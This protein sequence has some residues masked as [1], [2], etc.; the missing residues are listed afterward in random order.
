VSSLYPTVGRAAASAGITALPAA[1]TAVAVASR[2][3]LQPAP[4]TAR[5]TVNM[6]S[7]AHTVKGQGVGSCY[8]EQV[9]AVKRGLA[10]VD[11]TE[12]RLGNFDIVHYH[13]I[14][15]R[16]LIERFLTR[17]R[18]VGIAYV[19]F[20][21][22]TLDESLRLPRVARAAFYRYVLFFYNSMDYLVTVNPSFIEK[23]R[24]CGLQRPHLAYIPNFVSEEPF[25][26]VDPAA[27]AAARH[28]L[29]ISDSDF[30]VLGVGQ[31]QTRKGVL[32]FVETARRLPHIRF[33]WAGGFSFGRLSDGYD[34]IQA[35]LADPPDNVHFIGLVDRADMPVL[36]H[37]AD[38]MF[39][40]SYG[41]L[42]PMA[43]LEAQ[44]CRKPVLLRDIPVYESILDGCY[45][46]GDSPETFARRIAQ[47]A[48]DADAYRY[49]SDQ[50]WAAHEVYSEANVLARW[51]QL[52][53]TA[54]TQRR[55]RR[56]KEA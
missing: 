5:L 41:E 34:E 49:W 54:Y 2:T 39:L 30:V 7:R 18:T 29:G 35:A 14:N 47:L 24:L 15:P 11:I 19:H 45:L 36:Y 42:F 40:P 51:D 46:S 37:A 6:R 3:A 9:R 8:E 4:D 13:T 26:A 56:A 55:R 25:T 28:R 38:V 48:T 12:N 43:I 50:S 1:P 52:Y 44:C 16:F 31:L 23:M 10:E 53:K 17:R 33:V 27:V 32:D 22:E 20:L 21:P